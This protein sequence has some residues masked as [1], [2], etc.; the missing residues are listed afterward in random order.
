MTNE[1]GS[2]HRF[3]GKTRRVHM[4]GIG[5]VGMSS[6]AE[7]LLLRGYAV[8][9]SDLSTGEVTERLASLGAQ[10]YA[11]HAAENVGA[12]DVV[13]YSSAVRPEMN[14]ETVEATRRHIPLIRRAEM[15]GELMRMKHG[16]GVAGTH[17]K[18]TTTSMIGLIAQTA[19]LEPTVIVGG[20]VAAFGTG[21]MSGDGDLIVVEADEYDRTFLRLTPI[22]AVVTS[23]DAEHLDTY[24]G[25]AD[26]Q[27]AFV[28]FANSVPFFGVAVMCLDDPNVQAIL[29]RIDRRVLTYGLTR[30]AM[31]RAED[32]ESRGLETEFTV[33]RGAEKL[34]RLKIGR[35][36]LHT[37]RNTLAAVGV[38]T[39][40]D[41]PFE[42]IRRGLDR[43]S[44][45]ERRFEFK[46]EVGEVAVYDDYAHHP[47]EVTATLEAASMAFPGRRIIAV[48]QPHLYS[49]TRDFGDE[50]ARSFLDAN[51]LFVTEVYAAREHPIQGVSGRRIADGAVAYGH[52]AACFV[53]P[54]EDVAAAVSR[55]VQPG[56]LV[57]T[58]GAG[59][60]WRVGERLLSLLMSNDAAK[61]EGM[62][63]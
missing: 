54:E 8:S 47:V 50:F 18:T 57:I 5:G 31:L 34:G 42:E 56:D 7:V 44:G 45:V 14:P 30:Q 1:P 48:F 51:V 22:I 19:G 13:V 15:L 11:G 17:G 26:I 58:M 39:E 28:R 59:D 2:T 9:G 4:V 60:I 20:K 25:L 29:N 6:I 3:L 23:I 21:A 12:A 38:A 27:D 40:L 16:V 55:M 62:K 32:V 41:I 52:R 61:I 63:Q 49:R 33:I 35:P 10:I 46:G 53:P 36:G 24:S 43:F 37:V